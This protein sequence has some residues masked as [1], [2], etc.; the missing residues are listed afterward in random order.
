[1]TSE[2]YGF[3]DNYWDEYPAKIMAVTP[4]DITRVARKYLVPDAIQVVAVGDAS[5]IQIML[6]KFGKVQVFAAEQGGPS[7]SK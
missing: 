1:V 4:A 6:E 5:K 2:R 3:P 7:A